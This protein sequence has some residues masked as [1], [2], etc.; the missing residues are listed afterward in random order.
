MKI[1]LITLPVILR[2]QEPGK[3]WL[4]TNI[5]PHKQ[6]RFHSILLKHKMLS[7]VIHGESEGF[8]IAEKIHN[9]HLHV[10]Q[11]E[12]MRGGCRLC[13]ST[14]QKRIEHKLKV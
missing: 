14:S 8:D 9:P 11:N 2:P 12:N 4:P 7:L 3:C 5:D 1:I 6:K 10:F 13:L